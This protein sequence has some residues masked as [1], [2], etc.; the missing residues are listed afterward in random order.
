[1]KNK[2]NEID[3]YWK[4]FTNLRRNQFQNTLEKLKLFLCCE[5]IF[6]RNLNLLRSASKKK[7]RNEVS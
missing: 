3:I 1:M 4:S 2:N 5:R 6:I 7:N